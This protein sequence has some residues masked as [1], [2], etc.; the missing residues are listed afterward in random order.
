[1]KAIVHI[2]RMFYLY[3]IFVKQTRTTVFRHNYRVGCAYEYDDNLP[4]LR[5]MFLGWLG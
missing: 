3:F 2:G 4:D 5:R 1:M